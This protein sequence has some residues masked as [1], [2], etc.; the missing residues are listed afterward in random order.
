[1]VWGAIFAGHL[2]APGEWLR[3]RGVAR[4]YRALARDGALKVARLYFNAPEP[5]AQF[6]SHPPSPSPEAA[7]QRPQALVIGRSDQSAQ[8]LNASLIT[9]RAELAT[10][11]DAKGVGT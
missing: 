1:M 11:F 7:K 2:P 9:V 8:S 4:R 10:L 6:R 5:G 3:W